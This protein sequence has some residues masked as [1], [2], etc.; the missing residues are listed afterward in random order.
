MP[1]KHTKPC[2]FVA[3]DAAMR[4]GAINGDDFER[5]VLSRQIH[6]AIAAAGEMEKDLRRLTEERDALCLKV[7]LHGELV[8]MLERVS[9]SFDLPDTYYSWEERARFKE[10]RAL[11]A[12][13]AQSPVEAEGGSDE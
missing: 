13:A 4:M 1:S 6:K 11:L 10:V 9:E 7:E 5:M 3:L 12:R 8:A 2:P